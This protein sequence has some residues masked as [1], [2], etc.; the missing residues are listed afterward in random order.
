MINGKCKNTLEDHSNGKIKLITSTIVLTDQFNNDLDWENKKNKIF[1][2]IAKNNIEM[3]RAPD[4]L[5]HT[6]KESK[7]L[8]GPFILGVSTLAGNIWGGDESGGLRDVIG[9]KMYS[10]FKDLQKRAKLSEKERRT[11]FGCCCDIYHLIA[12]IEQNVNFFITHDKDI[13]RIKEFLKEKF[14]ICVIKPEE[15]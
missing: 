15:Y 9:N 8:P 2:F 14:N 5:W 11:Y 13:L 3:I 4:M 1:E 6:D 7:A 12:A 10:N